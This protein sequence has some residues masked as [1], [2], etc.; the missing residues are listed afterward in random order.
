[1]LSPDHIFKV[2]PSD[3]PEIKKLFTEYADSLGVSLD[4]QHFNEELAGL[5]GDYAPPDGRLL[6][7]FSGGQAAGCIALRKL[8]KGIC[9]MKRLYVRPS[10]QGKQIGRRLA[11]ALIRDA[12]KIGYEKMRLDTLPTMK[13]AQ[14]LYASLGFYE[15]P[16]YR[17]NPVAGSV[18][19]ELNLK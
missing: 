9:E 3:L 1:M 19:M 14:V 5:P 10:F 13:T 7:A 17:H 11:E 6:I 18:F 12:K 16:P 2:R 4:F 8:E 15:I